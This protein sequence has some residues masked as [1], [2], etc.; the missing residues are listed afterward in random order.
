M[1]IRDIYRLALGL[2]AENELDATDYEAQV[3]PI[4]NIMAVELLE[5][6]RA[7]CLYKGKEPLDTAPYY[8]DLINLDVEMPYDSQ[9]T[10][11]VMPYGLAAK[12]A[13]DDEMAKASYFNNEYVEKQQQFTRYR[14]GA[15]E[16]VY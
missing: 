9:I 11:G 15:V 2:L 6:N 4:I 1:T 13:L 8:S 3:I 5:L 12:L 16:E 10:T 7:I 14:A